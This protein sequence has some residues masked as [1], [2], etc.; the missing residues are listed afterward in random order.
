MS[1]RLIA[2]IALRYLRGKGSANAVP[3]LSRI[4]IAAIAVSSCAMIILFSVFNGFEL[5]I[6]DLYKSFYPELQIS[7][8]QGKFFDPRSKVLPALAQES[9]ILVYSQVLE[10]NVLVNTSEGDYLPV[11]IRG[12][13][14]QYFAVN[15]L[16]PYITKGNDTLMS[17]PDISTAIIGQQIAAQLGIDVDNVFARMKVF[18]PNTQYD[19]GSLA[20]TN[21][22]R[23]MIVKPDGSF[24]VQEEFDSKYILS[25]IA[26]VQALLGQPGLVS[27]IA[28][29]LQDGASIPKLAEK[30]SASLGPSYTIASRY[31]Q[32]KTVY[33][34]MRSERWAGYAILLFVL[35][36]AS[37]NM[38]SALSLLVLEKQ[39]DMGI[40]RAMGMTARNQAYILLAEGLLWG[41]T[42]GI[43]GLAIGSTLCWAQ[44]HFGLVKIQGAFIIDAYPVALHWADALIV[45]ATV[46]SVGLLA[47]LYPASKVAKQ[48]LQQLTGNK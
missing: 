16:G 23:S 40:L 36:I 10:D 14:A 5:L 17:Q 38:V 22:F 18:Y 39:K 45:L 31:Q 47:A 19:A 9:S 3:V 7:A 4:S 41:L 42:G 30:L 1:I 15:Q 20:P 12:V 27:A 46:A 28:I 13:D 43:I 26:N 21:A 33:M 35:L 2:T 48:N 6:N 37:F 8:T 32:N 29:R 44:S 24:A 11:T 34:V 25:P